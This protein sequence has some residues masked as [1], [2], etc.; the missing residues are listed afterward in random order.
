MGFTI[1][2]VIEMNWLKENA[3]KAVASTYGILVGL[4]SIEHGIFEILQGDTPTGGIMRLSP[5]SFGPGFLQYSSE[6]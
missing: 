5:I 6:L 4:A 3:V 1:L 2:R